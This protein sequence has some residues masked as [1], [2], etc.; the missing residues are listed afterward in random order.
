[1]ACNCGN[2]D[3][4]FEQVL[5]TCIEVC[6]Y[7]CEEIIVQS[8]KVHRCNKCKN[9]ILT[10]WNTDKGCPNNLWGVLQNPI[11]N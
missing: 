2:K 8:S 1:M 7:G 10:L 11:V 5:S 9:L 3:L 4:T 6:P